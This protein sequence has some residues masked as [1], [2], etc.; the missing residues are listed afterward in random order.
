TLWADCLLGQA[1]GGL[2]WARYHRVAGDPARARTS[3][4]EALGQAETPRQPLA[5]LAAHRLLAELA[6]EL[7]DH[8]AANPPLDAAFAPADAGAA[9]Y[10]RALTLLARARQRAA[11]G[12]QVAAP[13][14]L[15][16]A[17]GILA[18]LGAAPA[19]AEAD[20]L[21]GRLAASPEEPATPAA[22]PAGL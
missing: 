8:A 14:A 19:L 5:L 9:I 1:E 7:D 15:D 20:A 12:D 21:L 6:T 22:L 11:P 3:A 13:A 10:E 17:R 4:A 2:L 18:G 16:E